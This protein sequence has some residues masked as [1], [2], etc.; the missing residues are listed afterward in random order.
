MMK[1]KELIWTSIESIKTK[2][3]LLPVGSIEQHGLCLPFGVD[4]YLAEAICNHVSS[5]LDAIVGPVI[6]YGARS[7]P[8]SGG[9]DS[10]PG[11]ISIRGTILIEYYED[12]LYQYLKAGFVEIIFLNAHWENETYLIEAVERIKDRGL[13]NGKKI[14]VVSWWSVLER[15][16]LCELIPDFPGW[17]FEHAGRTEYALM[18]YYYPELVEISINYAS[19]DLMINPDIYTYPVNPQICGNY[20]SLSSSEGITSEVGKELACYIEKNLVRTIKDFIKND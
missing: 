19:I 5:Y 20:G 12:I 1:Y 2:L 10:F 7:I 18:Q 15:D 6:P 14:M 13:L 8:N 4:C 17:K 11:T 16:T 9:G 3:L